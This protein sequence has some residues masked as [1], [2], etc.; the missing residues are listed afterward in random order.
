MSIKREQEQ[1]EGEQREC[2][3]VSQESAYFEGKGGD[4]DGGEALQGP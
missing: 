1:G 2:H 3:Q 4:C